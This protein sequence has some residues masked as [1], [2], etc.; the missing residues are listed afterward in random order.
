[1]LVAAST[2]RYRLGFKA[3]GMAV[4]F[5]LLAGQEFKVTGLASD[6]EIHVDDVDPAVPGGGLQL[7]PPAA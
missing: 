1:M 4:E 5:I 7:V 2:K 3:T 6:I